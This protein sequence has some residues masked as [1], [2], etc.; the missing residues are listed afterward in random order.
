MNVRSICALDVDVISIQESA[1]TAA[2]RM[3]DRKV[4]SLVVVDKD[5]RP[6]GVVTDRDL[7]IRVLAAGRDGVRTLVGEIMSHCPV[8]VGQEAS[9]E[10]ALN[11]MRHGAFRRVPVVDGQG[12][13]VGLLS[14]DDIL[15]HF[16]D[17]F[18]AIRGLI[19][20]EAPDSLA[21]GE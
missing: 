4:G 11:Q 2:R 21:L 12:K 16:A 18:M 8:T 14:L 10:E 9:I 6:L 20:R 5:G 1:L 3:N 19:E 7:T 15:K 13:L 17:E